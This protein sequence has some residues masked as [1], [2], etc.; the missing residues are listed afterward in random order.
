[1][2]KTILN[3]IKLALGILIV[4]LLIIKIGVSDIIRSILKIEPFAIV[5][6]LCIFVVAWMLDAV[7]YKLLLMPF[8]NIPLKNLFKYNAIA[9]SIGFFIPGKLGQFSVIYFLHREN[10]GIGIITAVSFLD[11]IISMFVLSAFS[12]LGFYIFFGATAALKVIGYLAAGFILLVLVLSKKPK[13]F[14][15]KYILHKHAAHFNGFSKTLTFLMKTRKTVILINFLLSVV[16]WILA[17]SMSYILLIYTS[18]ITLLPAVLITAIAS[19]ST[20]IPITI[21]GLGIREALN[22]FL[23]SR[24]GVDKAAAAG[25]IIILTALTY[26]IAVAVILFFLPEIR[27]KKPDKI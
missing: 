17:G 12:V 3:I 13:K 22:V 5:Y 11:K 6:L 16:K 2:K 26:C 10:V 24:I 9:W 1:M 7:N 23:F 4:Y 25:M 27:Q 8:K 21:S 18:E 14:V 19:I 20:L 15:K